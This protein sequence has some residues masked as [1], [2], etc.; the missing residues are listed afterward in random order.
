MSGMAE[1]HTDDHGATET[2]TDTTGQLRLLAGEKGAKRRPRRP[3]WVLDER[4]REIGRAGVEQ[5]RETL[6]RAQPP[7]SIKKAS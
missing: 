4:T 5:L 3:D 7:E 2:T 6:R 1:N